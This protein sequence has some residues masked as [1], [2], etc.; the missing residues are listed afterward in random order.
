M[1]HSQA[2]QIETEGADDLA[3]GTVEISGLVGFLHSII[4]QYD[5][6]APAGTNVVVQEKNAPNR[7]FLDVTTA[8]D[9]E[10]PVRQAVTE[11][12]GTLIDVDTTD[13][14]ITPTMFMLTGDVLEII[15]DTSDELDPA[16]TVFIQTMENRP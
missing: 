16:V 13:N 7:V 1:T 6:T 15:V 12:D 9:G 5:A 11:T 10:Y 8:T 3:T 4:V 2:V 14:L